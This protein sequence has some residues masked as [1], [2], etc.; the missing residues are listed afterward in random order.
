MLSSSTGSR[1]IPL[2][3]ILPQSHFFGGSAFRVTA[4]CDVAELCQPGDLY[5]AI[6]RG[7]RD[8]HE[9]ADVALRRGAAGVLAERPLPLAIPTCVV[10]DS[11]SA[12]S[13]VCQALAGN[14]SQSLRTVG[15][16]GSHGKTVAST[17]IAAILEEAREPVGLLNS[18]GVCDGVNLRNPLP[19]E[20]PVPEVAHWLATTRDHGCTHA[21][22]EVSSLTLAQRRLEGVLLDVAV[23]NDLRRSHL[24]VHGTVSN[25]RRAVERILRHLKPDGTVVLNAD[26]PAACALTSKFHGPA[27]TYGLRQPSD[28]SGRIL[29]VQHGEQT[30]LITH[31]DVSIAVTTR[32]TGTAHAMNCLAAAA[33]VV[34]LGVPLET[35]AAG[36]EAV[37]RIPGRMEVLRLGHDVPVYLDTVVSPESLASA[38][39]SLRQITSGRI[40]CV[41]GMPTTH[42]PNERPIFGRTLENLADIA[43][44]TSANRARKLPLHIA[45]DVLDGLERPAVAELIPDRD[46]ALR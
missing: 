3:E 25:Y 15:V 18:L 34:S 14:P 19:E 13:R 5:A 17:L 27:L 21:V 45:H 28:V 32:I 8:G 43:V 1:G 26:D 42:D 37:S 22:L 24:H 35:V 33:A 40:C 12:F 10:K 11:R 7:D 38:L 23:I 39:K 31:D 29:E 46:R 4:C 20:L 41:F 9:D 16:S 6:V 44:L 36:L 30:L 2:A